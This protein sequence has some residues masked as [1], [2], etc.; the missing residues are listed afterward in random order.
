M[1]IFD[2]NSRL[3]NLFEIYFIRDFFVDSSVSF[4][5]VSTM[6]LIH[7]LLWQVYTL[8][9]MYECNRLKHGVAKLFLQLRILS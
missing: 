2:L 9:N 4:L 1:E 6:Y 8:E 3:N 5:F 7:Q